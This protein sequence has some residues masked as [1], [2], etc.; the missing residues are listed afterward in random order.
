MSCILYSSLYSKVQIQST[1]VLRIRGK[2][3]I[4]HCRAD[5]KE[6]VCFV[7]PQILWRSHYMSEQSQAAGSP[8]GKT[9]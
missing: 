3:S 7:T 6:R 5:A 2:R 1:E 8:E 9:G 4:T